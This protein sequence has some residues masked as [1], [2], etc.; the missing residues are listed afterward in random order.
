MPGGGVWR[1]S[2]CIPARRRPRPGFV[3]RSRR[4][5][6]GLILFRLARFAGRLLAGLLWAAV[7][8]VA[9]WC[10]LVLAVAAGTVVD[11]LRGR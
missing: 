10:L 5:G 1:R 6:A 2:I 3:C 11:A 4:E 7:L 9:V 8:L